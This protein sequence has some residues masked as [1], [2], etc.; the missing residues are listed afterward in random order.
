MS[1]LI[2]SNK[3]DITNI[4]DAVRSKTGNPSLLSLSDMAEEINNLS[5]VD[6]EILNELN[7]AIASKADASDVLY[8]IQQ[9]L[10]DDELAQVRNNLKFIGKNVAGKTFTID[11]QSVVASDNA[12]I[13]G[14]YDNNIAVGQWSIAE[15]CTTVAKGKVAHAEGAFTKALADGTHTEGYGTEATGYWSHAEGEYTR[16]TSYASHAEG[17]YT[18]MPDGST[19]YSTA[20][21]YASHTEGGGCHTTGVASHAEGIG[22]TASGRCAHVEGIYTIANGK[23]QHVEG[24]ANIEDT[25]DKYIHI[26]GNGT[27]PTDRSNAYTLDWDGN[28]W[29]AGNVEATAIILRSSTEGSTKTFKLTIDD[30]GTLAISENI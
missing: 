14:D 24:I 18:K 19:R 1:E 2:I 28:G 20:A 22:T 9:T 15:G 10:S 3:E 21:G 27:L 23:A 5:G 13:F 29:F 7:V 16:V 25:E 30:S 8:K 11:G 6:E 17:S 12:E 4:A 26:A